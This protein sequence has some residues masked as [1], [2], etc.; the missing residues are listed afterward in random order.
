MRLLQPIS[1]WT[2]RPKLCGYT[3]PINV[4]ASAQFNVD[5]LSQAMRIYYPNQ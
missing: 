4:A 5:I 1:M 2:Y 3:I